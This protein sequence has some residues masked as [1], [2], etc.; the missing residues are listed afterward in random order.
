MPPLLL[1]GGPIEI[2]RYLF[3][4]R[5]WIVSTA[6]T[7]PAGNVPVWNAVIKSC[8][9][10]VRKCVPANYYTQQYP[11]SISGSAS[12]K[13]IHYEGCELGPTTVDPIGRKANNEIIR[14]LYHELNKNFSCGLGPGTNLE[15]VDDGLCTGAKERTNFV[16]IGASH[17]K[18]ISAILSTMGYAVCDLSEKSW[19]LS[20]Q[21]VEKLIEKL[22]AV[23][24]D[25]GTV[26][27]TDPLSNTATM[28]RQADDTLSIAIKMEG[29]GISQAK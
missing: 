1:G 18:R 8:N 25:T 13:H 19:V 28:Y 15:R 14:T 10:S 7:D 26:I 5:G 12:A 3:E 11:D 6:G 23:K 20:D 29:G 27:V 9:L 24:S 17:M 16:T 4:L 2:C 22:G 21:A